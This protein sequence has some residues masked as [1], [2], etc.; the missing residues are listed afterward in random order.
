MANYNKNNKTNIIINN[1]KTKSYQGT[2]KIYYVYWSRDI[3]P[4]F[5]GTLEM[6]Q[7]WMQYKTNYS[8]DHRPSRPE[9]K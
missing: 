8:L 9:F 5:S 2:N 4:S 1:D 6:C 7:K 3:T